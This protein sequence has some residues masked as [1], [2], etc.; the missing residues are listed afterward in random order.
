MKRRVLASL[1]GLIVG[2]WMV[3]VQGGL[4]WANAQ[5]DQALPPHVIDVWPLPGVE[6]TGTEPLTITFDQAMDRSTAE[7]AVS[8]D[9]ALEGT[10]T[11]QDDRT[12]VFVPAGQ[13]PR[14]TRY[15]VM[16]GT[17]AKAV[18]G[19]QLEE[20]YHF[21]VHT[22]GALAI[23]AVTPEDG[24]EGVASDAR[25][26][27][28]FNRPVVPLISTAQ[29]ADLPSPLVID[30]PVAGKG[31]WLN[32]SIYAFTPAEVL[33]GGAT[34]IVTV[35]AGL[36]GVTG[37][38][39]DTDVRWS[40]RTL[41]PQILSITPAPHEQGVLL[42]RPVTITFSQPM[43]KSSTEAAFS[44]LG[45]GQRVPGSF[46]WSDDGTQMTFRP[47]EPLMIEATY[48]INISPEA[49]SAAGDATLESGQ[50]TIF[51][52]IP[53][54]GI[55][56]TY[57]R[58]GDSGVRPGTGVSIEF[59][60]PMNTESFQNKVVISPETEWSPAVWDNQSLGIQF[61]ALPNT[62]YT[63]TFL[64]GAEDIYGNAIQTDYTFRFTT[65]DIATWAYPLTGNNNLAILAA[66]RE[67]TRLPLMIS[68]KPTVT[69][70]LYRLAQTELVP[71]LRYYYG[72]DTDRLTRPENLV[73][74]WMQTFDSQG[75][76]GAPAEVLL[77][78]EQGGQLPEG[79]YWLVIRDS[80]RQV[81]QFPLV[82]ASLNLTV[83]QAPGEVLVWV[84][85]MVTAEA[86]PDI[87]VTIMHQGKAIARGQT[88]A[89]G[90]LRAPVTLSAVERAVSVIAEGPDHYAVWFSQGT[91]QLPNQQGYLYTDRPIYRPGQTVYFRGALRSR[92]DMSYW[93]PNMRTVH[94]T[95]ESGTTGVR[96]FEG[97]LP[98]TEF[99]TFS[100]ELRL[101]VDAPIGE[102]LIR[103]D[104][105]SVTFTIAE[106]RVPEYQVTVIPQEEEVFQGQPLNALVESTYYAG[107]AVS[108]AALNWIAYGEPT[109]FPYTGPGRY[110]FDDETQDYFNHYGGDG[111]TLT[112][113]SGKFLVTID[114][115][116]P[117]TVR[118]MRLT[119]E[120]T[121]V[122]ES[123]QAISGRA[124]VLA[125]PANVYVGLHSD[126][127]FGKAGEPMPV[128]LIA[129]TAASEPL[130]GKRIDLSIVEIRWS[131][132][133][134]EGQYGR[135]TWTQEEIEVETAQ[136]ITGGDGKATYSFIPP[137]AGIYRLRASAMDEYERR[138]ASTLR[139]WVMGR[140]P[141]WWGEPSRTLDLLADKESY[142]PGDV[143]QV[144]V[145]IPFVGAST[146]LVSIE[147]AGVLA[148]EV[149][150]V[151][152]STLLYELPI[153][154][155]H[156][157]T[158][159]VDVTVVKGIDQ[160][161]P[162]PD[163]R[164]GQI[165]LDIQPVRQALTVTVTPSTTLAQPRETV[166]FDLQAVDASGEPVQAEF[167]IALTDKAILSLLPPNSGTLLD[168]FYG[169]QGNY[170]STDHSLS[171]L[172][173][174]LIDEF[175][176]EGGAQRA[177]MPAEGMVMF[178]A[179][180]TMTAAPMAEADMG[181][182]LGETATPLL[183][184][185][186]FEQT[187][188][189]T[190][191]VVTGADGRATVSVD[192]PDNLT[193]W[194]F[195]AR[196]LTVDTRVGQVTTEIVTTL[197]L[198]IR[199]VAPR[200]FVV[201]D[202]VQLAAVINNNTGESQQVAVTLE[203]SGVTLRSETT[204][205][206][207]IAAGMRGRVNWTVVAE[208]VD[209]VDLTFIARS[210]QGYQDASKPTL[211][212]GPNNTIPVYRYT[213]PD[214]VG[215]AGVLREPGSRTEGISLPPRL[216]VRQGELT[217][218]LDPSLAVTATDTFDYLKNYPHQCIEQTVS[219]FLP[220]A[221]TY[222]ALRKLGLQDPVL[223]ANLYTVLREAMDKLA[224]E[225]NPDGGW[226]WF[227]HMESNPLVTAYAA[228]GL[229]EAREAG[230]TVDGAMIDRAL[231]FV[232]SDLI[233]P[234][235]DTAA[236][237]LSRQAFYLYVLARNGQGALDDLLALYDSRLKMSYQ[238][239]A[240][241]LMAFHELYPEQG[242]VSDLVSDLITGAILSATGAHW[243]E[244]S[245]DWWN[246][247]SD[248]RTTALVLSALART[249]PDSNLLPNAVRW[250]MVARRGDHWETTQENVWAVIALTDW[251][252]LTGE[253][254]GNYEYALMV[255]RETLA[256]TTVTPETVRDGQVIRIAVR[257]LLRD[258]LNR[259]TVA[260]GE[261][262]GALY[263][264]AH[265]NV[266]LPAAEAEA[267][268]RGITVSREYFLA[269]APDEPVTGA[270]I[271][272]VITVRLTITLPED[273]YYFVLE[274]P[275]PAGTEGVDTSLL[276]TSRLIAG[277][278]LVRQRQGNYDPYW[279]WGWWW[280]DHTEMRDEQVNLYAD[281]LPR[282]TYVYTYQVRA[283]LAGEFQTMPAHA[284]AF[285]FPEVF[286]RTDG[287]LFTVVEGSSPQ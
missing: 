47:A 183:I 150:R 31:E 208:D 209:F 170:V 217:I 2:G 8:F 40:F 72:V 36:E 127:Y 272:D 273:I 71:A 26:V 264:T 256:R 185:E 24:A 235:V 85:D 147:R 224:A 77:A 13:W 211:A 75:Q 169:Q 178:A 55:A 4:P 252:V 7:R 179:M 59:R 244:D 139:F 101:P 128:D 129:V 145:P 100:G 189:W 91:S 236:W 233:R 234:R 3:M 118:P 56:H 28:T 219:R 254:R 45:Y 38:V 29:Q 148:Y 229:I 124:S 125:H 281:F 33:R 70:E 60:S 146:V 19:L 119:V 102:A 201:D 237:Q 133:P 168:A 270:R 249:V 57:P 246:W 69:F 83:K 267:I 232:R 182:A 95:I 44:L 286:G 6:M 198:L 134:V 10:F 96:L 151:E 269:D 263:Y 173:D 172:L 90:V 258:E 282:G 149:R 212:T 62:T 61:A 87:T 93:L 159:Y 43:D 203:A 287:M 53:Y 231:N 197:P 32:T 12:L 112:D 227:G 285:Y 204:Q 184:R 199:P 266:R 35:L 137:D 126:Q 21:D 18:S 207:T 154:E 54:P 79:A 196:G 240:Y 195:D 156:V 121:V 80:D 1:I 180:P 94:V 279:Y 247:G 190:P 108:N 136:V 226:G 46:S 274:D 63:I 74:A 131:R 271:G 51:S 262:E 171:V 16:I 52:T 143:A 158:I 123:Q 268:S 140:R 259:V 192:L 73:R 194:T 161:S 41:P 89:D 142:R 167:G 222:R 106:F 25:I 34:Y 218:R 84:T 22:V 250:L 165:A 265:L 50:S 210:E 114:N 48:T 193:T 88:S 97:E 130:A 30:P 49:R 162:N 157:P 64:A 17:E 261:G 138:N 163:Y 111:T 160:E 278:E 238:G 241:L 206:I 243:E 242:A 213:A 214:V 188:L 65:G 253:L 107:G 239:R 191:H 166:T 15:R 215:T 5:P 200:F 9:P 220:N 186:Q 257:D 92:Q 177:M 255:N 103:A 248:T 104:R 105:A 228:L 230:L 39:L 280:F 14:A 117:A 113:A 164:T 221:V 109:S 181:L 27:V 176:R 37:A 66:H 260:R 141:V 76:E 42:D 11:W 175:L 116:R 110:S 99:G 78:S 153:T 202:V 205:T 276:T 67:H 144:L 216:D 120:A 152:G 277:P 115:T 225:Q 82:V 98:V 275:I 245:T 86:V 20:A 223:E 122:D 81:F 155:E 68:G 23:T 284:Y 132:V 58:N 251:M 135:Y 187:P 174:R 283:S